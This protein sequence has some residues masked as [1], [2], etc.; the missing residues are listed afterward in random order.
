M[1]ARNKSFRGGSAVK[2]EPGLGKRIGEQYRLYKRNVTRW[3]PRR[4]PWKPEQGPR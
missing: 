3:L 4:T 1:S 2:E